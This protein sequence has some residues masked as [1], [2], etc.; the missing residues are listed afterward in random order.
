MPLARILAALL[1]C[2]SFSLAQKPAAV[3]E[4]PTSNSAASSAEPWQILAPITDASNTPL[5]GRQTDQFVINPNDKSFRVAVPSDPIALNLYA[6][7]GDDSIC[8]AIRSYVVARDSKDSDSVHLVSSSTCVPS[9]IY[10]F[11][12]VKVQTQSP[13]ITPQQ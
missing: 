8:Y 2:S 3:S 4:A 10:R 9:R 1:L 11:K 12:R 5:D 13:A 6:Q 7:F